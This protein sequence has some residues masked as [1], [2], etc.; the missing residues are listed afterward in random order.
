MLASPSALSRDH[1]LPV[2]WGDVSLHHAR[3]LDGAAE[4][5]RLRGLCGGEAGAVEHSSGRE[6]EEESPGV[7]VGGA[8]GRAR[9]VSE[10]LRGVPWLQW[11]GAN[12]RRCRDVSSA[13]GSRT[14]GGDQAEL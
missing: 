7:H 8:G 4:A 3:W 5:D 14:S 9:V 11:H 1:P 2:G 6:N 13:G 10:E 12:G